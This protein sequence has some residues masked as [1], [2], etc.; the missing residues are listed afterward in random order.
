M[1]PWLTN[2]SEYVERDIAKS[3]TVSSGLYAFS[4]SEKSYGRESIKLVSFDFNYQLSRCAFRD[5]GLAKNVF[6]CLGT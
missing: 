3:D 4:C 1:G 2:Q 5:E 6:I